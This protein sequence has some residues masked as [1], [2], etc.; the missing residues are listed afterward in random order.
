MIT[1]SPAF[2]SFSTKLMGA[3]LKVFSK[4]CWRQRQCFTRTA[5]H[6]ASLSLRVDL[7]KN[8]ENE[9]CSRNARWT[10][11]AS[12]VAPL[13]DVPISK[14]YKRGRKI[15]RNCLIQFFSDP[16]SWAFPEL[17]AISI[18]EAVTLF[19]NLDLMFRSF[20]QDALA[21]RGNRNCYHCYHWIC[22]DSTCY[23][24]SCHCNQT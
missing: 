19:F 2:S 3:L 9:I 13:I 10:T 12:I 6:G 15:S 7:Q 11:T 16:Q 4:A 21:E 23:C 8:F 24:N 22:T 18:K 5:L 1:R 17:S 20:E 14:N